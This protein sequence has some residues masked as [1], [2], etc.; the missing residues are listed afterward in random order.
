[1]TKAVQKNGVLQSML[2]QIH[3][4]IDKHGSPKDLQKQL[5]RA[6][7]MVKTWT[8]KLGKANTEKEVKR[9]T[10]GSKKQSGLAKAPPRTP[11][12]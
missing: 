3:P 4:L 8:T 12:P 6:E 7:K 2:D 10:D 1:M 5:K 11:T 9:C